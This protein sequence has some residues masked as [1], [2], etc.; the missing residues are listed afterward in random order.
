MRACWGVTAN[1]LSPPL[2]PPHSP[3]PPGRRASGTGQP[4]LF[5]QGCRGGAGLGGGP[6]T[7]CGFTAR[8][9]LPGHTGRT[10]LG[11][12]PLV[13]W[14]AVPEVG[15]R[16]L[17]SCLSGGPQEAAGHLPVLQ[18]RQPRLRGSC[19]F[20]QIRAWTRSW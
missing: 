5:G 11:Q 2:S 4:L 8:P 7:V 12:M 20:A 13:G 9:H 1:E 14:E 6:G 19:S 17:P 18:M 10:A 3:H 15:R 16:Q